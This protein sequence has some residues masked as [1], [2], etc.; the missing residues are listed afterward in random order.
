MHLSNKTWMYFAA[1]TLAF[2]S[3]GSVDHLFAGGQSESMNPVEEKEELTFIDQENREVTVSRPVRRIVTIP[4]PAASMIIALDGGP[5]RLAGMNPMSKTALEEGILNDFY[6]EAMDIRSDVVGDGF[7]PNP[8]ALLE[9]NP[10]L[11]FQWGG[12]GEDIVQPLENA[13]LNVGLLLYGTQEYLEGWIGMFGEVLGKKEKADR[14]IAWHHSTMNTIKEQTADIPEEEK[15]RVLYFLRFLSG[16]E[17]AGTGT[18]NDFYINFAGG[19]N[20]AGE[21]KG[22]P[23]PSE[24]QIIAWDPEIILLNGFESDLTPQH[25]YDNAKLADV[26]AV[27]NR[28][29]YKIPLGGY[30]WDPPNQESPLMWKWLTMVFHPDRFDWDLRKDIAENYTWIYGHTPTEEQIDGILR[31]RMNSGASGYEIFKK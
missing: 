9:V 30:R 16:K 13:G 28:R 10:D 20:P 7:M 22:F 11:I 26:S 31:M 8:E 19:R 2:L 17:V 18:Y 23:E 27:K 6:P 25:V 24:E 5:E 15:P 12:R 14:I 4:I 1:L 3:T 29:V 21:M